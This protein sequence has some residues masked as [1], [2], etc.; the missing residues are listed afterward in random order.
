[1]QDERFLKRDNDIVFPEPISDEQLK[2]CKV[3]GSRH[4]AVQVIPENSKFLEVGVAA[5][6]YSYW[7][8]E[9]RNPSEIF[10]L[11]RFKENDYTV[12]TYVEPRFNPETHVDFIKNRFSLLKKPVTVLQGMT[13]DILP[14][15]NDKI[16][17]IYLDADSTEPGFSLEFLNAVRLCSDNGIIGINDYSMMDYVHGVKFGTVPVVNKFLKENPQWEVIAFSIE[18]TMFCDI[19]IKRRIVL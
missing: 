5:G 1:M 9:Q 7:F 15:L 18:N 3:F 11:D 2:N 16:D 10:L 19:Y 13:D 8:S 4:S 6:D 14:K 17:Y 12:G